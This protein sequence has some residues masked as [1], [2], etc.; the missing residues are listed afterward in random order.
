[1]ILLLLQ[2]GKKKRK[3]M[4]VNV[5][6]YSPLYVIAYMYMASGN[7]EE[8]Y[9]DDHD[10]NN[11]YQPFR[12]IEQTLFEVANAE[13]LSI[14]LKLKEE[15]NNKN[16]NNLSK[17]SKDLSIIVQEV[18][19][20]TNRLLKAGLVQKDSSTG[21]FSLTTFG[22]IVVMQLSA[23]DFISKNRNY[24]SD[25]TLGDLPLKFIQRVGSLVNSQLL[26]NSVAVFEYQKELFSTSRNY[27]YTILPE[28]PQYLID[29][30]MPTIEK[31]VRL[32]YILS[33][34]A[35]LPKK[36]HDISKHEKFHTLINKEIVQRRMIDNIQVGLIINETQSMVSFS[37][38]KGKTDMNS[39]FC[40]SDPIFHDWCL[41]YFNYKWE[42]SKSFN[43][44]KITEA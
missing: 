28:V 38:V 13:R 24:F 12:N 10:E 9:D 44:E 20:H 43:P 18:H 42:N 3:I 34:N 14:L 1:M 41:D 37:T 27:I 26:T 36:R 23:L 7:N 33:Y 2:N 25:H 8:N 22:N 39:A 35:V 17:L 4:I 15:N 40:S 19:R 6:V 31:G 30:V 5:L 21:Y 32:R 11:S 16:N 29:S